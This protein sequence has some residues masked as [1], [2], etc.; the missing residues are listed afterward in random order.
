MWDQVWDVG[1]YIGLIASSLLFLILLILL[2]WSAFWDKFND[3]GYLL[4]GTVFWGFVTVAFYYSIFPQWQPDVPA[5]RSTSNTLSTGGIL[6]GN[7]ITK[8]ADDTAQVKDSNG[9]M[10]FGNVGASGLD[11]P[12]EDSVADKD[13]LPTLSFSISSIN[14]HYFFPNSGANGYFAIAS[15]D[16]VETSIGE[17]INIDFEVPYEADP[18]IQLND[19]TIDGRPTASNP[20]ITWISFFTVEGENK[21]SIEVDGFTCYYIFYAE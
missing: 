1:K 14:A 7:S 12:N 6:L 13:D 21:I 20:N 18:L 8:P 11:S 9:K 19:I 4:K 16:R 3:F 5:T 17:Q 15:G 10:G 2:I